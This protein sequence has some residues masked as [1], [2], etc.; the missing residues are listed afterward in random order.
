M[1]N[2]LVCERELNPAPALPISRSRMLAFWLR[3]TVRLNA[4]AKPMNAMSDP[5]GTT[6]PNHLVASL[7]TPS[8][9]KVQLRL[10]ANN[11]GAGND[12]AAVAARTI[13]ASLRR[14]QYFRM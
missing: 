9:V 3:V 5:P 7:Q 4:S 2:A 10:V 1:L 6:P 11:E 14:A 12:A 8:P 13:A